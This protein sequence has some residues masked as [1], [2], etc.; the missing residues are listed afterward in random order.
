MLTSLAV[1]MQ[2]RGLGR[3]GNGHLLIS[4]HP[5]SIHPTSTN[6]PCSH[7]LWETHAPLFLYHVD[8]MYTTPHRPPVPMAPK[9]QGMKHVRSAMQFMQTLSSSDWS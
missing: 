4:G 3:S 8:Q 9:V 1:L 6:R 7:F 2:K 5:V